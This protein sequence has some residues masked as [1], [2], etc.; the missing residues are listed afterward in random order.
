MLYFVQLVGLAAVVLFKSL[1]EAHLDFKFKITHFTN[2]IP[3]SDHNLPKHTNHRIVFLN[4]ESFELRGDFLIESGPQESELLQ[5]R[6][7]PKDSHL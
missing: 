1:E 7:T 5:N 6:E 3:F 4:Q 2:C